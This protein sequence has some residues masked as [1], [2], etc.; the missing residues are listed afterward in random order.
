MSATTENAIHTGPW[1]R[2]SVPLMVQGNASFFIWTSSNETTQARWLKTIEV[3]NEQG[4]SRQLK[5]FA[6]EVEPPQDD[7][8][9][10]RVLMNKVRLERVR[11]F[12]NCFV[13][14]ELVNVA[15]CQLRSRP[16]TCKFLM[17][18]ART[19]SPHRQCPESR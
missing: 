19:S 15:S 8:N 11:Q 3:F 7:P 5:L 14:L 16:I 18:P 10:A 4:E 12:G 2:R 6:S 1:S 9:V 13:G 17:R